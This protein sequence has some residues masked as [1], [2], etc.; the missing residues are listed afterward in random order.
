[1]MDLYSEFRHYVRERMKSSQSL[2]EIRGLEIALEI[3]KHLQ[4]KRG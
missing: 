4:E 1:M 3:M 2:E